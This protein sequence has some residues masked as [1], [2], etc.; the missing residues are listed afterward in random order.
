MPERSTMSVFVQIARFLLLVAVICGGPVRAKAHP[1]ESGP[2]IDAAGSETPTDRAVA[3]VHENK[4][5]NRAV[6]RLA[7]LTPSR[8]DHG[9]ARTTMSPEPFGLEV[10]A[11]PP[12]EVSTKWAELQTRILSEEETLAACRSGDGN[13]PAAARRFL[14]IIET[15]RQRQGRARLGEINRAVNLSIKPVSDWVQHGVEDFWSAPLATLSAGAGDCEDYAILKYVALRQVGIVPDN[16]RLVIVRDSK[17]KTDH[18][19]VTVRL[20]E[21]WLILDNRTL[22]M[23]NTAEARHYYPL[24]V[25]DHRGVPEFGAAAFRGE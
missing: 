11:A 16:L 13:C 3:L 10:R 12:N 19:V 24:F 7:A 1:S 6:P 18:A 20:G 17:R 8:E 9:R 25:L 21:E 14:D 15:G 23:V 22:T 4:L 5:E 2:A